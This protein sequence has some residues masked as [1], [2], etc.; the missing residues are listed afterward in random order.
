MNETKDKP[1]CLTKTALL[2]RGW[3]EKAIRELLPAPEEARNPRYACASPMLLWPEAEV[4]EREQ[5]EEFREFARRKAARSAGAKRAAE[6]KAGDLLEEISSCEIDIKPVDIGTLRKLAL[7]HVQERAAARWWTEYDPDTAHADEPTVRRWMV[8]YVR[9]QM[10]GYDANCM[11]L[12]GR[13]GRRQGYYLLRN[14]VLSRIAEVY[15]N[16]AEECR[17]QMIDPANPVP[18]MFRRSSEET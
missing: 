10:T 4:E 3:S 7:R 14:R 6:K 8:N 11:R 13:V 18:P 2:A 5:T 17:R 15:P 12:F 16:L 1:K 9:H